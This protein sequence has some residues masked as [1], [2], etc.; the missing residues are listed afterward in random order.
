MAYTIAIGIASAVALLISGFIWPRDQ[1]SFRV[2][3]ATGVVL[4]SILGIAIV[5]A[6]MIPV[7]RHETV[8][9]DVVTRRLKPPSVVYRDRTV[10]KSANDNEVA[11]VNVKAGCSGAYP[12]Q[13][14]KMDEQTT[15]DDNDKDITTTW[16]SAHPIGSKIIIVCGQPGSFSGFWKPG[17]VIQFVRGEAQ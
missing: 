15:K 12:V 11:P 9:K 7:T 4:G 3:C 6:N 17:D 10:Y 2:V 13:I 14:I 8:V 5:L 16:V 1:R